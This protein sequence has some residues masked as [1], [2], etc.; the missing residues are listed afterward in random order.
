MNGTSILAVAAGGAA[1]AYCRYKIGQWTAAG[2]GKRFPYGTLI[3][4]VLGCFI[5]GLAA[6]AVARGHMAAGPWRDL[7]AEGFLGALTTFSTFSMDTFKAMYNGEISKGVINLVV[8]LVLCLAGV[9]LGYR[10]IA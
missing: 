9:A 6:A 7:I 10:L 1:G 8:S 3:A 5:M 2:P 4:N